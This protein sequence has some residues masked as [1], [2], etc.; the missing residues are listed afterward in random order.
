M[1]GFF[2]PYR[3]F[4]LLLC[5][6]IK[7]IDLERFTSVLL[8]IALQLKSVFQTTNKIQK[9]TI[10]FKKKELT[11]SQAGTERINPSSFLIQRSKFIMKFECIPQLVLIRDDSIIVSHQEIQ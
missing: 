1:E 11:N 7:K 3:I 10:R 6:E 9:V 2:C 5:S 8:C 4:T